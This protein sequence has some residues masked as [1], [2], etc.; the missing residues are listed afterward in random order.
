MLGFLIEISPSVEIVLFLKSSCNR[1]NSNCV[2]CKHKFYL[3]CCCWK[4]ILCISTLKCI[5]SNM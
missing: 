5:V 4:H 3:V 2:I 1:Q